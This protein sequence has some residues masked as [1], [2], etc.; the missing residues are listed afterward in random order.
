LRITQYSL[1]GFEYCVLRIAYHGTRIEQHCVLRIAYCVW[2]KPLGAT[3]ARMAY[4]VIAY[5]VLALGR[6]LRLAYCVLRIAYCVLG[7]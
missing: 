2:A 5:C 3:L 7:L 1:T 6:S 4:C